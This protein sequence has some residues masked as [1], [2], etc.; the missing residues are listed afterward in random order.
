MELHGA[1]QKG[2]NFWLLY[3]EMDLS[4]DQILGLDCDPWLIN[5]GQKDNQIAAIA[6]QV[7]NLPWLLKSSVNSLGPTRHRL[8]PPHIQSP[9][10]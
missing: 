6:S 7:R 10:R 8:Y 5:R 3:E 9:T 2:T 4:L 1:F